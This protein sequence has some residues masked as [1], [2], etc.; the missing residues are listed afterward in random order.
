MDGFFTCVQKMVPSP[1]EHAKI[2]KEMEIYMMAGGTFRVD[3]AIVDRKT[4]MLDAWWRSYGCRVPNL[5]RLAIQVLNQ[6]CISSECECKWSIFEKIHTKKRNRLES[7]CLNDMVYVYYNLRLWVRQLERTPLVETISLDGIDTTAAWRVEAERPIM[8]SAPD[9]LEE[10]VVE[11][12]T[13]IEEEE[14]TPPT[15]V[16]SRGCGTSYSS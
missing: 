15:M 9:W 5:Q 2:S 11:W 8:E 16:T 1:A 14:V 13:A 12:A 3:M 7:H 10:E 4:K 6:T